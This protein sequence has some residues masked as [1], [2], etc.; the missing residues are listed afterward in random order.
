[1]YVQY[2][3]IYIYVMYKYMQVY[4]YVYIYMIFA[5]TTIPEIWN[6]PTFEARP[7]QLVTLLWL[8]RW[9]SPGWRK[10]NLGKPCHLWVNIIET[11]QIFSRSKWFFFKALTWYLLPKYNRCLPRQI[12]KPCET[13]HNFC[14]EPLNPDPSK[15]NS[16]KP[17]SFQTPPPTWQ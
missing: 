15:E 1:M 8:C 17:S 14:P 11:C 10:S 7:A 12:Q 13:C 5:Y 2:T 4:I 6:L 3:Y 16:P 9:P